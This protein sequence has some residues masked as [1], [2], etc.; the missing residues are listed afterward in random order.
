MEEVKT[1]TNL[2]YESSKV[3]QIDDKKIISV[4]PEQRHKYPQQNTTKLNLAM[5][6]KDNTS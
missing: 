3:M 5:Q 2:F 4:P 6:R 1:F